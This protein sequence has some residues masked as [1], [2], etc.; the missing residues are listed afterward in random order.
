MHQHKS[1]NDDSFLN[2]NKSSEPPSD[3]LTDDKFNSSRKLLILIIIKDILVNDKIEKII[4]FKDVT[5][6]VLYE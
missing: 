2:L 1:A 3:M 4:F 6:G 5:F